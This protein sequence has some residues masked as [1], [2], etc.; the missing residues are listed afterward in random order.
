MT[1]SSLLFIFSPSTVLSKKQQHF[2][3]NFFTQKFSLSTLLTPLP[4]FNSSNIL[5]PTACISQPNESLSSISPTRDNQISQ[6]V[7]DIKSK[8]YIPSKQS[9]RPSDNVPKKRDLDIVITH[10]SADFDSLAAAVGLAKL[11]GPQTLVV[12]PGGE[13]PALRR[14]LALHRQLYKII[15]PKAVDPRRLRWVGVVDTVRRDRLGVAA[16]WPSMAE[17]VVIF[18][19]H[20]GRVCDIRN[21]NRLDLYVDSVGAVAT[22]ICERLRDAGHIMTPAEATLLALAIH[23]DTGSLTYEQT[24]P[25]DA[26]ALAW[27]MKQGAIQRSIAEF[28]HTFLTDEQQQMLSQGLTEVRRTSLRGVEIGSLM[29]VGRTFLKGMSAVANDLLDIANLDVLIMVYVNC[30]GN[31]AKKKKKTMDDDL[32]CGPEQVKQVSVIGRARA[33]VE[34]VD[35]R[36]VFSKLGG[37]GHARAASASVKT[38]EAEAEELMQSLVQEV[39][40]QIPEPRAVSEFMTSDL[41]SIFPTA[42]VSQARR[43]MGLHGHQILPV[44]DANNVLH[45]LITVQDVKVAERKRGPEA[46]QMPVA[47]WIH[48]NVV[49]VSPST[50]FYQAEKVL[51]ENTLG[52]LPIVD[53]KNGLLGAITRMDV[54]IARRLWP[55]QLAPNGKAKY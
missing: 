4:R 2:H 27:L 24:T 52:M 10:S 1:D 35:F 20:V 6:K 9:N 12:T 17:H 5:Y 38:T 46:F 49:T 41:I 19:H 21:N 31:R 26:V 28:S 40:D 51:A 13:G 50:P 48:H 23:S 11:R 7:T 43:L 18:D 37:G 15:D 39:A 8:P 54:L 34:G 30:R 25:R 53:E 22:L 16:D 44:V 14:F 55:E 47:A 36:Q 45:G 3:S 29:L 42:P 32:F 33:R